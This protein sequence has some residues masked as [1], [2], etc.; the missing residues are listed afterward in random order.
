MSWVVLLP[1]EVFSNEGR[2]ISL[3]FPSFHN[4]FDVPEFP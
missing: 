1:Y 3:E 2:N 4:A